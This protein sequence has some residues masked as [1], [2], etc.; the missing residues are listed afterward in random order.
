MV[1]LRRWRRWR[2]SRAGLGVRAG[3]D[4]P[5]ERG[6]TGGEEEVTILQEERAASADCSS[7]AG[8][9]GGSRAVQVMFWS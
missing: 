9:A 7:R 8:P 6:V 3:G 5:A 4:A 1:G 2:R